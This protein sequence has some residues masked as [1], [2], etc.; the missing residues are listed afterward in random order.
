M[1]SHFLV[2]RQTPWQQILGLILM[3]YNFH[4]IRLRYI[5]P[6]SC[7]PQHLLMIF[8]AKSDKFLTH[9]KITVTMWLV[10]IFAGICVCLFLCQNACHLSMCTWQCFLWCNMLPCTNLFSWK[11]ICGKSEKNA[12]SKNLWIKQI[13]GHELKTCIIMFH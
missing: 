12:L 7:L 5:I 10:Q 1:F 9:Q 11:V 2:W 6:N 13:N 3:F 4:W 8:P